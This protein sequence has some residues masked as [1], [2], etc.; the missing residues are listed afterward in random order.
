MITH[1]SFFYPAQY[2][3][4]AGMKR[5]TLWPYWSV[6]PNIQCTASLFPRLARWLVW[7]LAVFHLGTAFLW[8][9]CPPRCHHWFQQ[10][11]G[12]GSRRMGCRI[13]EALEG[14]LESVLCGFRRKDCELQRIVL[15]LTF[16]FCRI[17]LAIYLRSKSSMSLFYQRAPS[18]AH[19]WID[20]LISSLRLYSLLYHS[21]RWL[22]FQY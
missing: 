2:C 8:I 22:E 20:P 5:R 6:G 15:I 11:S 18:I 13:C 17:P 9:L 19:Q 7:P 4:C 16:L 14:H 10:I 1:S 3:E 21:V 12:L